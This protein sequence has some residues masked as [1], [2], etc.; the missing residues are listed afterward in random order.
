MIRRI[1]SACA[2]ACLALWA[3]SAQA[4][5]H[6]FIDT[7]LAFLFDETGALEAIEVTW[8]YDDFYSLL[9]LEDLGLDSDGDGTL[10]E[11]ERAALIA[12]ESDWPADYEGDVFAWLGGEK[13]PLTGPYDVQAEVIEGRIRNTH[14]MKLPRPFRPGGG[15]MVFKA[16]DPWYYAFFDLVL[17]VETRGR[18][19]CDVTI[20]PADLDAAR[21]KVTRLL[22]G[23]DPFSVG[24]EED[25]PM[26]GEDFADEITVTCAP[27]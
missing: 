18:E 26:V 1:A 6:A 10:T 3:A 13:V 11:E 21:A 23:R 5:P 16:Y 12:Y 25:F 14:V 22:G 20:T 24:A 4:H 19:G 7:G 15:A 9:L 17:P 2:S 8:V 27:R